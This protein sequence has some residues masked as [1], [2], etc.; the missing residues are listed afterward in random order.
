M[1]LLKSACLHL[2]VEAA[3]FPRVREVSIEWGRSPPLREDPRGEGLIVDRGRF[4]QRLLEGARS[5]G[6]RVHQPAEIVERVKDPAGWRLIVRSE[7]GEARLSVDLVAEA[8]GR[9]G[10]R[11]RRARRRGPSTIAIYAYW[12]GSRLRR[13]TVEADEEAWRWGVPLPDGTCNAL[14]F[15]DPH[16]LRRSPGSSLSERY[17]RLLGRSNLMRELSD[18]EILGEPAAIDATPYIATGCVDATAIRIGDAALAFDPISSSGVQKAI[19]T[20]LSGAIVANT[21][22]RKPELRDA[23]CRFYGDQLEAASERHARWAAEHYGQ[24]AAVNNRAFWSDR[25]GH[26]PS[27]PPAGPGLPLD[28][29]A[30]AATPVELAKDLKIAPAPCLDRDFV[31]YDDAV[32]GPGLETPVVYLAGRKLAPLL[33]RLAAGGTPLEIARSWSDEMPIETGLA[34]AAWLI[35]HRLLVTKVPAS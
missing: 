10:A 14:V 20:A 35:Q 24:V 13:P 7:A 33:G 17:L 8:T 12:R 23:A 30:M 11:G 31:Q 2:G 3:S 19:Q 16:Q 28:A 27:A 25:A 18:S 15:V 26:R 34:I 32:S 6:V 4:D 22:L 21:L 9:G 29:A 5:L 1:P